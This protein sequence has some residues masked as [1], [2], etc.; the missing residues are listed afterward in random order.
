MGNSAEPEANAAALHDRPFLVLVTSHWLSFLGFGLVGTALITWL[1]V[2]AVQM[3]GHAE[4]PYIGIVVFII[5][6]IIFLAGLCIIPLGIFLGRRRLKRRLQAE[7]V[8]RRRA[9]RRLGVF[10]AVTTL[11]NVVLGTQFT[12]RAVEHMESVQFCGQTCHVMKPEFMAHQ[13]SPHARV[14][15]VDCHVAPGARGWFKSKTE[16]T[17]QLLQVTFNSYP[18]PIPPALETGR[19]VPARETCEQCHWPEKFAA[20]K[21]RVLPKFGDDETNTPTYTVLMMLVGGS[22][23]PGI[24]G[25]HFAPGVE[26]RFASA[27]S[28]RQT[29]PWVEY[30][31]TRTGE[32]RTYLAP[33]VARESVHS[34]PQYTMQCVDCHNRPTHAFD[35]PERAVDRALAGGFLPCTLPFIK[36]KSVELLKANYASSAEAA[37]RIPAALE[38]YYRQTYP[39]KYVERASDIASAGSVLFSLYSRNVF[40][41]LKVTWGTYPNNVGHQ[42]FP[43]CF[44]CHDGAHESTDGKTIT[45]DCNVCHQLLAVDDA[46]PDILKT[47]GLDQALSAM[48]RP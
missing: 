8:D 10:L 45:Q 17:R 4:N 29:I 28:Q 31:N 37:Q 19:L 34:L 24:H 47:M 6:P 22:L 13:Y 48:R 3:R 21:L 43:G 12:Y 18:R 14:E 1:F 39:D 20:A 5:V 35:L 40:P 42:D 36:T 23:M 38:A 25:A 27:D 30:R 41:D 46:A 2:L 15:C 33:V 7:I 32:S 16:G 26:I 11:I 44:R 9:F